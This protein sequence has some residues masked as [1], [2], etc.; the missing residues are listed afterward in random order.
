VLEGSLTGQ[1]AL[2]VILA[3]VSGKTSGVG[4]ASENYLSVSGSKTRIA[5]TFDDQGNR[6]TVALDGAL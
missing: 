1:D 4:T 5:A 2:R 3:A 6:V